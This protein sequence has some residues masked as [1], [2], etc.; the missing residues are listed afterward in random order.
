MAYGS[1]PRAVEQALLDAAARNEHVLKEPPPF[2][3]FLSFGES[4]LN[5]ELGCWTS[6]MLHKRGGLRSQINF[7]IH[8]ILRERGITL[9]FPQ[10][11]I[12]IRSA[13]GLEGLRG[14]RPAGE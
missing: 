8:E 6:A 10:R 12:H 13:E 5:F 2:V 1:D 9:P 7:A 11:D 4:S 14:T 3:L